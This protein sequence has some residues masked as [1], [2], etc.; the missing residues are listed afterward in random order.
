MRI[1][2]KIGLVL[3]AAVIPSLVSAQASSNGGRP[4]EDSWFWGVKGG[5]TSFST[6]TNGS[7]RVSAPTV[8]GEWLITRTRVAMYLSVEQ[9]FF[10]KT[11]G[12]FDASAAG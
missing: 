5:M 12:V 10:D 1:V 2:R 7:A 4:F 3:A 6:G 9:T 8:G 11:V